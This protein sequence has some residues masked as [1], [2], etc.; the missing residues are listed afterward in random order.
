MQETQVMSLCLDMEAHGIECWL[1]GG[2][3]IDALPVARRESTTTWTS[4]S[5]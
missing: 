1:M 4:S 5:R 3:G 2:W